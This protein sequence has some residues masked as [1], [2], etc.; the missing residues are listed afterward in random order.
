MWCRAVS[1]FANP[2]L[3][4]GAALESRGGDT[5]SAVPLDKPGSAGLRVAHESVL[6]R[7]P[8]QTSAG[9]SVLAPHEVSRLALDLG[10]IARHRLEAPVAPRCQPQPGGAGLV[11]RNVPPVTPGPVL[12][13]APGFSPGLEKEFE[14]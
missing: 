1:L 11:E 3:K 13:T 7:H 4:P 12:C 6:V 5:D 8:A 10:R 9:A 2:G 14:R